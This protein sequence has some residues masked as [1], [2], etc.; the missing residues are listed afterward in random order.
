MYAARLEVDMESTSIVHGMTKAQC[1]IIMRTRQSY[2]YPASSPIIVSHGQTP[3]PSTRWEGSGHM[4]LLLSLNNVYS[5]HITCLGLTY[6]NSSP[7]RQ[8][9][10]LDRDVCLV[11]NDLLHFINW[12]RIILHL[13]LFLVCWEKEKRGVWFRPLLNDRQETID[14]TS[15]GSSSPLVTVSCIFDLRLGLCGTHSTFCPLA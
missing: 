8:L 15:S 4:R 5:Q 13:Y 2:H 3:P 12:N 10:L 14:L 7:I 6:K 11:F 9:L 1:I